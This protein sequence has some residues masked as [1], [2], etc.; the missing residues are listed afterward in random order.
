[1]TADLL[2][3]SR[4]RRVV[5]PHK[6]GALEARARTVIQS[7][8]REGPLLFL[9][10]AVLYLTIAGLMVHVNMI[11]GDA[12]SR[13][14]NGYYVLYS[15]YPHLPAVG[16]VWN[17]L[18]SLILLPLFPLKALFP[19]LVTKGFAGN[20]AS[21]LFM[22]GT[23]VLIS[24]CLRKLGV[25]FAWR[26]CLTI[27]FAVQPMI[28]LY[29]GSGMSE[30]MLLFFS[31]L[32]ASTL[33]SWTQDRRPAQLV[34]TGL[35]LGLAY[36][37]RYESVGSAAAV[38][39][40]V[41][42]ISVLYTRGGGRRKLLVAANDLALVAGPFIFSF[43]LWATM[44]K[45]LVGQWFPTF[46]SQYGNSAQVSTE[47]LWIQSISGSTILQTGLY[48]GRQIEALAPLIIPLAVLAAIVALRRGQLAAAV[49]PFVLGGVLGF[50]NASFLVGKSFGWLRFQIAVIPLSVLLAGTVIAGLTALAGSPRSD[51][52]TPLS[53]LARGSDER[54][55][56]TSTSR[57]VVGESRRRG[58]RRLLSLSVASAVTIMVAVGLPVEFKTLVTVQG[59]LAREEAPMLHAALFPGSSSPVVK[60]SLTDFVTE[61]HIAA[62]LDEM[63]LRA[64]SVL[65]DS[66]YAYSVVLA[67]D[68]PHQFVLTSDLDFMASVGDPTTHH[69]TYLL[70]PALGPADALQH[71]WPGLY[72][73]GGGIGV[74]VKQWKG[75]LFGNWRLYRV[76]AR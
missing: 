23:V 57:L 24:S 46:S 63:H 41:A 50:D 76:S 18:P 45:L 71:R 13:V 21:S 34:S 12:M 52:T 49:A 37:T 10:T 19:I 38:I 39:V 69:V 31:C 9:T 17:P 64:G 67:S 27:L 26:L 8:L 15:R 42:A 73:N 54:R 60:A 35:A 1:M 66:A 43:F 7:M 4:P 29:G 20:I 36:M 5:A 40:L 11:Y 65:T 16:F 14:A 51:A 28:V 56:P 6:W 32:V 75:T 58:T 72:A 55:A 2:R 25:P 44:A 33:I 74:L 53:A 47:K 61:R 48:A 22:A 30:P 59:G 62:Y 68:N 3:L 70:V